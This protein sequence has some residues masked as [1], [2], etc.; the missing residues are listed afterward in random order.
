M[1]QATVVDVSPEIAIEAAKV[2]SEKSI[3]TADSLI[4]ATAKFIYATLY[5]QDNDF[6]GF[7]NVVFLKKRFRS[8][9][10]L[11]LSIVFHPSTPLAF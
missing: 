2:S 4:L 7:D 9:S 10:S 11:P 1:Q 5:T 6:K 8:I 3:P